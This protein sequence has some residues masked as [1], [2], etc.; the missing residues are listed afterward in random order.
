MV[1]KYLPLNY[2]KTYLYFKENTVIIDKLIDKNFCKYKYVK[3]KNKNYICGRHSKH[4]ENGYCKYH[5]KYENKNTETVKN[6][7]INKYIKKDKIYCSHK[8][9][10]HENCKRRVKENGNL[11]IYHNL[12]GSKVI[13]LVSDVDDILFARNDIGLL[14]VFKRF[15]F[16]NF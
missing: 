2:E 12:Y 13:S 3:G 16:R 14:H 9:I 5:I 6:K 1:K 10:R 11:C 8:S 7:K 15:L 4:M